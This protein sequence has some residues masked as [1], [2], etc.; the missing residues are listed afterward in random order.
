M[1]SAEAQFWKKGGKGA[2]G[3]AGFGT[4]SSICHSKNGKAHHRI[5]LS[6]LQLYR[7][8]LTALSYAWVE[9]GRAKSHLPLMTEFV[10]NKAVS[11][12][13]LHNAA[14]SYFLAS[15]S[16]TLISLFSL[17]GGNIMV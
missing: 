13:E 12:A 15:Y 8:V 5:F 14:S 1:C 3:G 4:A 9:Q 11:G 10:S 16:A 7:Q 6:H 17:R 2:G